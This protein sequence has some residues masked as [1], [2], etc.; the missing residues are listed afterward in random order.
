M[1][2]LN[3]R[4]YLDNY[5]ERVRY[6]REILRDPVARDTKLGFAHMDVSWKQKVIVLLARAGSAFLIAII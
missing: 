3:E 6:C 4:R 5:I 2:A 1:L